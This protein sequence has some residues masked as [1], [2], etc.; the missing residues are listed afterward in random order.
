MSRTIKSAF[1]SSP[2]RKN[3][4]K[5]GALGIEQKK[6]KQ[7]VIKERVKQIMEGK[8]FESNDD[9]RNGHDSNYKD[10]YKDAKKSLKN[11]E[12]KIQN[13]SNE[14]INLNAEVK[15]KDDEISKLKRTIHE[16]NLSHN[17][18]KND[19]KE[20][21]LAKTDLERTLQNEI[22]ELKLK[23]KEANKIIEHRNIV[24]KRIERQNVNLKNRCQN[25]VR[26]YKKSEQK[27][28][29]LKIDLEN[30]KIGITIRNDQIK[31][32]TDS[33]SVKEREISEWRTFGEEYS[34]LNP[35]FIIQTFIEYLNDSNVNRYEMAF[36]LTRKIKQ[37]Q[38]LRNISQEKEM[39][40]DLYYENRLF[41]T[42]VIEDDICKF[43]D[44]NGVEYKVD[45]NDYLI[46]K[47]KNGSAVAAVPIS[48]S[49]V[50]IIFTYKS[51]FE[52]EFRKEVDISRSTNRKTID[53]EVYYHIGDFSVLIV[54]SRNGVKYRDRLR[55]HGL[56][57]DCVEGFEKEKRTK[58]LMEKAD[59]VILCIDSLSHAFSN[60]AK[61]QNDPKYQ[62]IYNHNEDKIVSRVIYVKHELGLG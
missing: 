6:E 62:Y 35:E 24:L 48:E 17:E 46:F 23:L 59:V 12:K 10:L 18:M 21:Q 49:K 32:L 38:R 13:Q 53:K 25:L 2:Y 34:I 41:G 33:L 7:Q 1:P 45:R 22:D 44:I 31:N 42:V 55:K 57:A 3:K 51:K 5:Q 58:E 30:M 36:D 39:K 60:F 4:A 43:V 52:K 54:S 40:N 29:T 16:M 28:E 26:L 37:I 20:M 47:Y 14:I 9:N 50:K 61:E 11:A 8:D 56:K 27:M 15:S 19:L